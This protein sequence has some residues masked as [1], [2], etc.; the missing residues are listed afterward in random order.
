MD[1]TTL[2]TGDSIPGQTGTPISFPSTWTTRGGAV[3]GAQTQTPKRERSGR[4]LLRGANQPSWTVNLHRDVVGT[5]KDVVNWGLMTYA[6]VSSSTPR[7][8]RRTGT[9]RCPVV[10][11]DT[12]P[13]DVTAIEGYMRLRYFNSMP[14]PG[15]AVNGGTPTK[16]AI[17]QADVGA[18]GLSATWDAGPE[19]GVQP[20][21]R[22]HLVH[23]RPVERLQHGQP[24]RIPSGTRRR[25]RAP[26]TSTGSTSTS[27][28][29]APRNTCI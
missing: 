26:R 1:E 3:I 16:G 7:A 28:L 18:R 10:T 20:R 25:R 11:I 9:R 14:Y 22:H 6:D 8:T 13:G 15:L 21:L 17:A 5:T 19:E 24:A 27:S 4:D 2:A 12:G 23:R 29:R